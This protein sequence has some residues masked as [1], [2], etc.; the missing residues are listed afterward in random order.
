VIF[1]LRAMPVAPLIGTVDITVGV[2]LFVELFSV[3]TVLLPLL[4]QP[5]V[6]IVSI[7]SIEKMAEFEYCLNVFI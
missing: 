6:K 1:V 4:P 2:E 3:T 5:A 7:N